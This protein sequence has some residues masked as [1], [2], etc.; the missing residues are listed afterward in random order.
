MKF[1]LREWDFSPT[2]FSKVCLTFSFLRQNDVDFVPI[3]EASLIQADGQFSASHKCCLASV[4]FMMS[5]PIDIYDWSIARDPLYKWPSVIPTILIL[6]VPC[7]YCYRK[8]FDL[9]LPLAIF[10]CKE[11]KKP[12]FTD[13][14][15]KKEP[16]ARQTVFNL[17]EDWRYAIKGHYRNFSPPKSLLV[18]HC[19]Y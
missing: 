4:L 2:Y 15:K 18:W 3:R 14:R 5:H 17:D 13:E 7:S 12:M 16:F 8:R 9:L 6:S 11:T 10:H 1:M 19:I